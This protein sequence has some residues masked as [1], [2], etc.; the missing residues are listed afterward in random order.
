MAVKF[1]KFRILLGLIIQTSHAVEDSP[2]EERIGSC[3]VSIW[4]G[5]L[6]GSSRFFQFEYLFSTAVW[7][8]FAAVIRVDL[9]DIDDIK[10]LAPRQAVNLH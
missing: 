6:K 10:G 5:N 1:V 8:P 2:G 7:I 3:A 9:H 4:Q